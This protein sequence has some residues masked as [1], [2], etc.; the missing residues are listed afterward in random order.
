MEIRLIKAKAVEQALWD[1]Q[2][3]PN[4]TGNEG[5]DRLMIQRW[6]A[7][8]NFKPVV[9][10]NGNT[11]VR[12][13]KII[14]EF[15]RI[16]KRGTLEKMTNYFYEFLILDAGSIAHYSKQGWIHFYGNSAKR[17]C[18]FFLH[19]EYGRDVLSDQPDWKTDCIEISKKF[20]AMVQEH[21]AKKV[22]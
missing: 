11:V 7:E 4:L 3:A 22:A 2:M 10:Y 16:L 13:D 20:L 12:E 6:I 15:N 19:N 21:R 18:D 8:R 17:L 1:E 9:L 14:S 5:T